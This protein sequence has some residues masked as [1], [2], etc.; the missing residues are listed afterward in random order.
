MSFKSNVLDEA[1]PS[2][3]NGYLGIDSADVYASIHLGIR[4]FTFGGN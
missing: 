4:T 2:T 1:R 3:Q